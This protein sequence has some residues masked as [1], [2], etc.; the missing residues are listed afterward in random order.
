MRLDPYHRNLLVGALDELSAAEV[1]AVLGKDVADG[2]YYTLELPGS[3]SGMGGGN[4]VL[5]GPVSLL[6][7]ICTTN[8]GGR[9]VQAGHLDPALLRRFELT[10]F[11]SPLTEAQI[12]PVYERVAGPQ[13]ARVAYALE[14]ASRSMTGEQGQ[15]LAEPINTGVT[16]N[17]LAEV[18][19]LM[20]AGMHVT[21]ALR[22]ALEVTVVPFC[23]EIGEDG[24]PDVAARQS[25]SVT[26]ERLLRE[27]QM[28]TA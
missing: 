7:V 5:C 4:E 24:L 14:V 27:K 21:G 19:A 9:Y 20:A 3:D 13:A 15:S 6:S 25:L 1:R 22:A 12:M 18:A 17:Y 2:R 26:L 8:M 11:V 28:R 10:L 16:L 23:C